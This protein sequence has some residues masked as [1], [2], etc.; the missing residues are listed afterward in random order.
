MIKNETLQKL[1]IVL[2]KVVEVFHWVG[3][4]LLLAAAVC[5]MVLP[6]MV[7]HLMSYDQVQA[8][9]VMDVYGFTIEFMNSNIT[10]GEFAIYCV[11]AALLL[12]IVAM[13]CCYTWAIMKSAQNHTPFTADNVD[14]LKWIGY[15]FIALPAA[16]LVFSWILTLVSQ[17][18]GTGDVLN[19]SMNLDGFVT[20]LIVLCLTQYFAYGVKLEQETEGLI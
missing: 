3:A 2:I 17:L 19:L 15:L 16:G 10:A 1:A 7:N 5:R 9:G 6:S 4:A 12:A 20:G 11:G 18:N 14:R 13:I 8:Q